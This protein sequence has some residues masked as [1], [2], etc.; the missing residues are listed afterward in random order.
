M[1]KRKKFGQ[2]GAGSIPIGIPIDCCIT[3]QTLKW[4]K[5][6]HF[7]R[8][9]V[10]SFKFR[11]KNW[12]KFIFETIMR[13]FCVQSR[14]VIS[15]YRVFSTFFLHYFVERLIKGAAIDMRYFARSKFFRSYVHKKNFSLIWEVVFKLGYIFCQER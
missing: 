11:I 15:C 12:R 8:V 3:F 2:N 4:P 10:S 9:I 14:K 7:T 1:K 13:Q 5:Y 6:K